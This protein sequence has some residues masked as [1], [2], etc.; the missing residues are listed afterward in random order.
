MG[1][2]ILVVEDSRT[3]AE[4]VRLLLEDNG[5]QVEVARDGQEGL[6]H[7]RSHPPDLIISD[8]MMP[9]MDGYAFCRAVKS[10]ERTKRIPFVLLTDRKDPVDIIKGLE[11]GADNFI[12]KPFEDAYLLERI[13]RIFEQLEY[14]KQGHMEV[15]VALH[16]GT[17]QIKISADKQQIVELLFSTFEE[18]CQLNEQLTESKRTVEHYAQDLETR[19]EQRTQELRGLFDNVPIGL[20][21]TNPSGTILDANPAMVQML[22]YGDLS[23]LVGTVNVNGLYMSD[24]DRRAFLAMLMRDEVAR[25]FDVQS[26][27][28]DGSVIWVRLNVRALRDEKGAPSGYEGAVQDIT[29]RRR[30]EETLRQRE[31]DFRLLFASNPHPMW[32]YDRETLEFIEVNDAAINHYGYTRDEF[33]RMRLTEIRDAADVPALLE[34]VRNRVEGLPVAGE[35]RHRVKDGRL[36]DVEVSVHGLELGGRRAA[37]TVVQDITERKRAAAELEWQRAALV[38]AEKIAAMGS[39]LAGVAH[40]LNNPLS[41]VIGHAVLLQEAVGDGPLAVRTQKLRQ[42]AERCGRIVKSFLALAR[43]QPPE[44]RDVQ[45]NQIVRDAV[46]LLA[47]QLRVDDVQVELQLVESLPL[48]WADVHQLVQVLVNLATNA[49]HAMRETSG[50]RRLTIRTGWDSARAQVHVAVEDSGPGIPPEIQ[51]RIF[52]PFFTTKPPGVGTG[53]GLPLCAGI[54]KGHGGRI[55]VRSD[56]GHGAV[57]TVELPVGTR[58]PTA[59]VASG[60]AAHPRGH[61]RTILVVDDEEDVAEVLAEMLS[62]EGHD[63]HVAAN[64][65]V[66]L[67]RVRE[68]TFDLIFSDLRMPE[69]DGPGL[70]REVATRDPALAKR[71]V[72]VTGDSLSADL[73]T[74]LAE[75]GALSIGKPFNRD[76]ISQALARALGSGPVGGAG[77]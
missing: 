61:P 20:Y 66:A 18:L 4:R 1:Q 65:A 55:E 37:L 10:A 34:S 35:W 23:E 56:P 49:H 72:F 57:F 24:D 33:L 26:R 12:T 67:D 19:V 32:V 53:L 17:R 75:T 11:R 40:E 68:R 22:G 50:P 21:R 27:R 15:E 60:A 54:V 2:T 48:I 14:R 46:E 16:V 73:A 51:G 52:E 47:Y 62:A 77:P 36:I 25:D 76:E 58:P 59:P 5:Y 43:Q 13:R 45:I 44:Y 3:Q 29:A 31:A 8:L 41:V 9:R 39:L 38:Q 28:A 70:Y 64:G 30:A 42:A 63:V 6:E 7:I 71:F 69:L 74:F